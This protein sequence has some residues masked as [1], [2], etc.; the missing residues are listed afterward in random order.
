MGHGVGAR[1][2]AVHGLRP[3]L[4]KVPPQHADLSHALRLPRR[5]R[6]LLPHDEVVD[7]G[8][9][10]SG[11]CLAMIGRRVPTSGSCSVSRTLNP[12]R[13]RCNFIP[14]PRFSYMVRSGSGGFRRELL[15]NGPSIY[16]GGGH[17]GCSGVEAIPIRLRGRAYSLIPTLPRPAA[18]LFRGQGNR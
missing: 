9:H 7:K 6:L 4:R 18:V 3:D 2:T 1:Q 14:A 8:V 5:V 17:G 11:R 13:T 10:C 16:E 12:G 15:N